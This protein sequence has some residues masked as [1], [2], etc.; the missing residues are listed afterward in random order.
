MTSLRFRHELSRRAVES[1]VPPHRR[2]ALGTAPCSTRWS[3]GTATTTTRGWPTTPR[4]PATP[5]WSRALRAT[6]PPTRP[7]ASVPTAR[8]PRSTSARCVSRPTTRPRELAE[9]YDGYADELAFVDRWPQA[10]EARE[11]AI[12]IWQRPRRRRREGHDHRKLSRG[13]C[14]GCAGARSRWPPGAGDRAARA[15]RRRPR[16][17]PRLLRPRLQ[18][19]AHRP[20]RRR[21]HARA[22]ARDGRA[23]RRPGRAQRRAQQPGRGAVHAARGLDRRR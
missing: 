3:R 18:R 16:A 9:L 1:A 19:L 7:P 23:D 21:R 12:E 11:R 15:A 8:R 13:R 10:A 4:A 22:G 5:T 2:V 17:R 6:R 20:G 14:G